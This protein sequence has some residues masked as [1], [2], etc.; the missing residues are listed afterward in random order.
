MIYKELKMRE[1]NPNL[2]ETIND[3][4]LYVYAISKSDH[5]GIGLEQTHRA[6]VV[7]PGGGYSTT[8]D[9]EADPIA[10]RYL[11]AGFSVFLL[12]YSCAPDRYPVQLL[13]AAA[14]IGHIRDNLEE[15]MVEE[16]KI[17]VCGFSAGGHLAASCGIL[18]K[19]KIIEETLGVPC[20]HFRP[21]G[22]ILCYPVITAGI[23]SH[24]GSFYNLLGSD[25]TEEETEA[26]SLENRVDSD[27]CPAFIWH[28]FQDKS[29][30]I[31]NTLLLASAMA[32]KDIPFEYHVYPEG[33][34]GL[35]LC[36][37]QTWLQGADSLI[38]PPAENWMDMS[39]TWM[40]NL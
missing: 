14:V 40:R 17:A 38:Y 32:E 6:V 31:Q 23:H 2:P 1:V 10:F 24:R 12:R 13:Q 39:I 19:E 25:A 18:W 27:T 9:R 22:M 7:L 35:A 16:D 33:P 34:H 37:R 26:M 3:A 11:A 20:E 5:I 4:T 28:T 8:S 29:V 36:N 21:N 30:P 15:Y